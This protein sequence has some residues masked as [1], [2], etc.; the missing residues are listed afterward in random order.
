MIDDR[1][2]EILK[3]PHQDSMGTMVMMFPTQKMLDQIKQAFK[4]EGW[5]KV[6]EVQTVTR[7]E[8][9][10]N[11]EVIMVNGKYVMTGKEWYNRFLRELNSGVA[12]PEPMKIWVMKCA[13]VAAGV[14]KSQT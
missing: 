1:L 8:R 7:Y 13:G 5:V 3:R 12:L 4:D 2:R 10:G 9:G 11:S 6:P 14:D